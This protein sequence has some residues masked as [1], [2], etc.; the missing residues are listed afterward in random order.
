MRLSLP[1]LKSFNYLL[2]F[3][4][5]KF[6]FFIKNLLPIIFFIF[7]TGFAVIQTEI[8]KDLIRY[9]AVQS[10]FKE[11]NYTYNEIF[12]TRKVPRIFLNYLPNNLLDAHLTNRKKT[13][14]KIV[15]PLILKGNEEILEEREHLIKIT[16]KYYKD[17]KLTSEEEVWINKK[18]KTFGADFNNMDIK[19]AKLKQKIDFVP[20]SVAL[21]QA[22]IETG[23]GT[24]RFAINGNALF[25]EWTWE[26]KGMLPKD[27]KDGLTHRIKTFPNMSKSVK[28]YIETINS[29]KAYYHFRLIREK[30]RKSGNFNSHSLV[31]SLLYYSERQGYYI[32]QLKKI[33]N[34][35]SLEKFDRLTLMEKK[36]KDNINE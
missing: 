35:N 20:A 31:D 18:A 6:Y 12:K 11:K 7:I 26:G 14:I 34:Q 1:Y 15:L 16:K 33:I 8:N 29:V 10:Y 27:R 22:I 5:E 3:K 32:D 25:A 23:W 4:K 28:S 30:M 17:K 13:F 21:A 19:L 36:E 2:I 9:Q 24:S